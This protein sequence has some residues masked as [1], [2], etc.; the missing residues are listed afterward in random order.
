[1]RLTCSTCNG[2]GAIFKSR[3]GG[4]D[5]DVWRD[6]EC[7]ACNGS[8]NQVCEARSCS[9]TAVAFND[10]GEALCE[11][12]LLEWTISEFDLEEDDA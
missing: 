10:D 1:M 7:E 8:G 9:E 2:E 3:Y 12:C 11:D 5:P 6:R 4:N